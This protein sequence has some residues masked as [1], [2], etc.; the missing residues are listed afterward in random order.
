MGLFL[1]FDKDG[2]MTIVPL[3][4]QTFLQFIVHTRCFYYSSGAKIYMSR[5]DFL[6]DLVF[7]LYESDY[8]IVK[9]FESCEITAVPAGDS[10]NPTGLALSEIFL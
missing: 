7:Y 1:K 6:Y 2:C 9:L 8:V 10:T 5:M 3:A 4:G